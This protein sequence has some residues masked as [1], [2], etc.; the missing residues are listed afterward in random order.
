MIF[1]KLVE[2]YLTEAKGEGPGRRLHNAK[3]AEGPAGISSSPVGASNF[4][5]ILPA[6]MKARVGD[7]YTDE[8]G[9]K[10]RG[11]AEGVVKY[12][13][14][15]R[16]A[17]KI[18]KSDPGFRRTVNRMLDSFAKKR[19]NIT[20][21]QE[22]ILTYYPQLEAKHYSAM[23]RLEKIIQSIGYNDSRVKDFLSEYEFN[24]THYEDFRDKIA[25]VYNEIDQV[26]GHN[27]ALNLKYQDDLIEVI[28][29]TA[30]DI[31]DKN[32]SKDEKKE[33][34]TILHSLQDLETI[35]YE[36]QLEIDDDVKLELLNLLISDDDNIN[37]LY[38]LFELL[39]AN[40]EQAKQ[41]DATFKTN[42]KGG[43]FN[44]NIETYWNRLPVSVFQYIYNA[45][46]DGSPL[47][48][49]SRKKREQKQTAT[50]MADLIDSITDEASWLASRDQLLQY[51]DGINVDG[52]RKAALA[53]IINGPFIRKGAS[54]AKR[55]KG[56]LSTLL[57]EKTTEYEFDKTLL[58]ILSINSID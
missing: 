29:S 26:I 48:R 19:N 41:S 32:L 17:F 9:K 8:E 57:K 49:L 38:K 39:N 47:T 42:S 14:I 37:P 56:M 5:P 45:T 10:V 46:P 50:P 23:L 43:R 27:E 16:N 25:D 21:Q 11:R 51:I 35:K 53:E 3:N 20:A 4:N 24:K 55:L 2:H 44:K 54:S 34:S 36:Q 12:E 40:Y 28:K 18:L 52:G 58:H 31:L 22:K 15:I 7:S 33:L 6:P 30:D 13:K 1:D